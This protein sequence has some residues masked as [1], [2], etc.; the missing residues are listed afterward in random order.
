MFVEPGAAVNLTLVN[1]TETSI[2]LSWHPP[3]GHADIYYIE[4]GDH[5]W[6][7]KTT[8]QEVNNRLPGSLYYI[9]VTTV[10]EVK[11]KTEIEVTRGDSVGIAA[12]TSEF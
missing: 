5:L 4:V 9:N 7:T 10:G 6:K 3:V 11:V 2:F 1:V 8:N 12:Y